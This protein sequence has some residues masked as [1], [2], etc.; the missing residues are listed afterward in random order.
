M[1]DKELLDAL[2]EYLQARDIV[3]ASEDM[4]PFLEDWRRMF[5]GAAITVVFPRSTAEVQ[6]IMR[7]CAAAQVSIVPQGGNTGLAGGAT[8]D[9]S[10]RNTC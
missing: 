6:E 1:T 9:A 3:T 7:T 4:A 5:H 2:G 8:P 10:G